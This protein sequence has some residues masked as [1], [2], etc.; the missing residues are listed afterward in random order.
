MAV[1]KAQMR[2]ET[3]PVADVDERIRRRAFELFETRGREDGHDL[4]DWLEAEAEIMGRA[5]KLANLRVVT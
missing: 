4:D 1:A 2:R 5:P 3:T